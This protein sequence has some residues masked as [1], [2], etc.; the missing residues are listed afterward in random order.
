[1]SERRKTSEGAS[2]VGRRS[3]AGGEFVIVAGV[4]VAE[5]GTDVVGVVMDDEVTLLEGTVSAR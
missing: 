2:W 4:D 3:C 5:A 1:M